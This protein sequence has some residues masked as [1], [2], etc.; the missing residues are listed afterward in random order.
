MHSW[1]SRGGKLAAV[2]LLPLAI[3]ACSKAP[4]NPYVE[5]GANAGKS[6]LYTAFTARPKHLDPAQSYTSDEAEFTYQIYE[7]LFQYHYLKRPYQLE[8]LAARALPEPVYLDREGNVLP[9]DASTDQ[10]H[11]SVYTIQIKPGILYQPHPAFAK[12]AQGEFLYHALG[13]E[14]RRYFSPLDF[15]QQGTRE[16]TA[17]DYVYEIKRLASPRIVSP[18]LG[19]MGEYV[20]GLGELSKTLQAND[21]A[22]KKAIQQQ[23]GSA[24]AP[25]TKDLPWL[26]LRQ[27]DLPGAKALDD[28]TLEIRVNGKYPQFVYWLAMPFFAP[29]PWE[30]DAFYSQKG[31]IENNLVL[32]WWPVGTGPYML[33]ENDPNARMVLSRNPNFRGEPYPSEGEPG[34][35]QAGL[36]ADAGKTMPFIDRVVFTR[37]KEGIPYWNKFL[38][39]YYDS[40]GVSA[41]TFDQAIRATSDGDTALTPDMLAKGIRLETSLATS[42]FYLG[43]NWLDP[44]VGPGKTDEDARRARLLRQAIAIAVDWEEFSQIFTNGRAVPA[45]G[46]VPPGLFGYEAGEAGYNTQVYNIV[47]GKPVRKPIA[48][49]LALLEQ[50]GYA[51]GLDSK[52]GQPLT[53]ALDTTG[54]GP[55]DKARFDWYRKQFAKL[56][57]QLEIRPTDWNR[58]QEKIRKGS[59][60]LFFLGWNAD[61]PDPEN[62]LFLLYGP[63]ARAKTAGENASNYSNAQYDALF[64]RMKTMP[65]TDERAAIISQMT[66]L[67]QDDVPW[68][69]AFVP[70]QYGLIHHWLGNVKPN[71]LARNSI[72]YKTI[73]T[74]KRDAARKEWNKPQ[75]WPIPALLL[76]LVAFVWPAWAAWKRREKAPGIREDLAKAGEGRG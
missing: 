62:F 8:P 19:H 71:D 9:A 60:Q 34:D 54:G 49:A 25:A 37:E 51:N 4:N 26:D 30:A 28:H 45:H 24:F 46:P 47:D 63:N 10:V 61:Y 7:P 69:F 53:L 29:I 48:D 70:Q 14:A 67:V 18:I 76:A 42:I 1:F 22:L 2:A 6:T 56:N 59:A 68:L 33:T 57:I 27:F 13:N 40:S 32:D 20:Q 52:T 35:M 11:T 43:F 41:D 36:L 23:T 58:F 39:G 72:K 12:N 15:E 75:W 73:V 21:E 64:E 66:D 31:F 17:H 50:A 55:G 38:Q 5:D 3:S 44:V 74:A 16:L 65:N